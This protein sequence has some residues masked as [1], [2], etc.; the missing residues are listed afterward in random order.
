MQQSLIY[1]FVLNMWKMKK[2]DEVFVRGQESL[3]RLTT[4]EVKMIL[5]TPQNS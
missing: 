4:D 5:E 1:P 2:V 3:G